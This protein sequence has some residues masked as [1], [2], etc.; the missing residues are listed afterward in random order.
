M[1]DIQ[2]QY[3]TVDE[4]TLKDVFRIKES[5]ITLH[6]AQTHEGTDVQIYFVNNIPYVFKIDRNEQ[7]VPSG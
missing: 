6:K 2:K 3:P 5:E 7:L 4:E 1:K